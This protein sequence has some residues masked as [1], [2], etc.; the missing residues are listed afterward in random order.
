MWR[1][2]LPMA[3]LLAVTAS[4][5]A[6]ADEG[7]IDFKWDVSRE[8]AL[9]SGPPAALTA[10]TAADAAPAILA[11]R[12]YALKLEPQ[13]EVRFAAGP[14]R[15]PGGD[16]AAFAGIVTLLVPGTGDYRVSIDAPLWI[17]LVSGTTLLSPVD[18]QGQHS[19]GAPHK[20]VVFS[21]HG[22]QRYLLQLSSGSR[23][24]VVVAV[25]P[26]PKRKG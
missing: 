12:A 9:F 19:C 4:S 23:D 11:D 6:H 7:C 8:R 14:G 17:D 22:G 18:F 15:G 13:A 20:I 16:R 26:A 10:G 21:L 3:I 24:G 1:N 2:A 5:A 25:T